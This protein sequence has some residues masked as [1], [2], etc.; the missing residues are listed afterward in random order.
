MIHVVRPGI[1][2][3]ENLRVVG[4]GIQATTP[5]ERA[6]FGNGEF[7]NPQS[8][9]TLLLMAA[10]FVNLAGFKGFTVVAKGE[11]AD[12][13]VSVDAERLTREFIKR[14]SIDDNRQE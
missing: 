14:I 13:L 9:Q 6:F 12:D 11:D 8:P 5:E 2:E 3:F 10:A 4:W 7:N 1:I